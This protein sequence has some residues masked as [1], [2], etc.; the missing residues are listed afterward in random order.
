M[1]VV[2]VAGATGFLGRHAVAAFRARGRCVRAPV[3]PG[4]QIRAD[5]TVFAEATSE[6]S[7]DGCAAGPTGSW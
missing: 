5:E 2:L 4:R 3:R 6:A 1:S 7:L